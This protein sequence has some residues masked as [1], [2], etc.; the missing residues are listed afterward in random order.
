MQT[1]FVTFGQ[2]HLHRVKDEIID[3]DTVV[4]FVDSNERK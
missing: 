4:V 3:K 2:N 1:F